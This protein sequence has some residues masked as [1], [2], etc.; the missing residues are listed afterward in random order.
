M[1]MKIGRLKIS[2][3]HNIYSENDMDFKLLKEA[4]RNDGRVLTPISVTKDLVIISGVRRFK[5]A[6]ALGTIETVPIK[7][8]D[9]N[10]EDIPYYIISYN[11]QRE[12]TPSEKFRECKLLETTYD[13]GQGMR[14]DMRPIVKMAYKLRDQLLS[15]TARKQLK[16]V[17]SQIEQLHPNDPEKQSEAW[18]KLDKATSKN[19]EM[20]R[21]NS[22]LKQKELSLKTTIKFPQKPK[23]G[24]KIIHGDCNRIA[25]LED[26][27]V[28]LIITSPPYY[29][30][31]DYG[32]GKYQIGKEDSVEKYVKSLVERFELCKPKL[33]SSASVFV[34]IADRIEGGYYCL[35]PQIF[36]SHMQQNGWKVKD[37]F[38]WKKADP[39]YYEE[40]A[41]L[42]AHE[43]LFQFVLNK[44]IICNK[45]WLHDTN[46]YQLSTIGRNERARLKSYLDFE[47]RVIQTCGWR[48]NALR[49]A[50]EEQGILMTHSASFPPEIPELAI[51]LST[52]PG[53]LVVDLFNGT[54]TTGIVCEKL[55]RRYIGYELQPEYIKISEINFE[56]YR[57]GKVASK[58]TFGNIISLANPSVD[59]SLDLAA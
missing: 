51:Q 49:K 39:H 9:I 1:E 42:S 8:E 11:I 53:Q 38:I 57:S 6:Q 33:E 36:A 45:G 16:S 28:G 40:K 30:M 5:A 23:D 44:D 52:N 50:C 14:S 3:H 46:A 26:N 27:S 29:H 32:L 35:A 15:N 18:S 20:A 47:E 56:L 22:L 2:K 7:I 10:E 37:V 13:L 17:A 24:I 58:K 19:K 25:D 31:R 54:G 43:F 41:S 48:N 59:N 12:K 55:G 21:I 4:I 34:N